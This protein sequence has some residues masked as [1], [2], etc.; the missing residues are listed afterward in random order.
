MKT[1]VSR[2]CLVLL[3]TALGV[4]AAACGS[5]DTPAPTATSTAAAETPAAASPAAEAS[6]TPA[7]PSEP[8]EPD[9]ARILADVIALAD[10]IG[11]RPTGTDSEYEAAEMLAERLRSLGYDVELQEFPIGSQISRASILQIASP[12]ARTI[13]SLPVANSGTD[14]VTGA[15]V[16]AG[17]GRVGDFP[18]ET[19]GAIALIERGELLFDEK[20]A[21]AEAAGAVGVILYNNASGVFYGTLNQTSELPVLAISGPDGQLLRDQADDSAVTATL[22]VGAVR[23]A[24]AYNVVATPPGQACETVTGGHYDSVIQ[25]PGASD[26]ASGTAAVL[27]IA[28]VMAQN[29]AMGAHCFVLF[30]A[31]EIGLIGSRYYV[32]ALTQAERDGI[33]A[34]LNFDMVGFGDEAWW[35]IG[36]TELQ[37]RMADLAQELGIQDA[38][39]SVLIRGMSSDHA[40][41]INAGIPALMFHRWED[42]L[43]HTPQDVSDRIDPDLLE[44]AARMGAALLQSLASEG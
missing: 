31:E 20:V 26:N 30:G 5:D 17:I 39:S 33:R 14:E 36:S 43:L 9:G 16:H 25:A 37:E 6:P 34:M 1:P 27:E 11:P 24:T 7:P 15:V 2:L 13:T 19:A 32:E 10:D 44:E 4:L 40:S 38:T 28:S 8:V 3:V 42:S 12:E 23:D 22:S 29:G 21:N 18:A 35:L 41:F